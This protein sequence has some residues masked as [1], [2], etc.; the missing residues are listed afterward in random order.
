MIEKFRNK[1]TFYE[2]T[3]TSDGMGG[4]TGNTQTN[5][6][7]AWAKINRMKGTEAFQ[8]QQQLNA[9]PY[10]LQI[11]AYDLPDDFTPSNYRVNADSTLFNIHSM[12][13]DEYARFIQ[14]ICWSSQ[15]QVS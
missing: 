12:Q 9:I 7:T 5:K 4:I 2:I 13:K 10:V 14:L 3:G 15:D 6:G 11:R 1:V 8:L